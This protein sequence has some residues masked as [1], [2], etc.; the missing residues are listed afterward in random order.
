MRGPEKHK[1]AANMSDVAR[2]AGVSPQTVSRTLAGHPNVRAATAAKVLDAVEK[3]DY[4]VH[5]AAASLSSGRTRQ[6]GVI[7][8][9]SARY[10][11][12]ALGLGVEAAAVA[13]GYSV[14]T[15]AAPDLTP[16]SVIATLDRVASQGAEGI[17]LA[18]PV[19]AEHR[20]FA[21][22]AARIPM[23]A[24]DASAP[25]IPTV[26]VDQVA[27]GRLATEHLLG[28]GHRTVVHLQGPDEWLESRDRRL[29]WEVALRARDITP[30]RPLVGDWS[31]ESGYR[32]GTALATERDVTALFVASDEMAFGVLR[33]MHEHGRRVPEDLSIVSVD[34]IDL[35]AYAAPSLTTVRQPFGEIGRLAAERLIDVLEDRPVHEREHPVPE[36]VVRSST[37]PARRPA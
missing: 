4:R 21:A 22:R 32:I 24:I 12:S 16:E 36:L 2:L 15:A 20:D 26:S 25:A 34:D 8:V 37:A 28:L 27:I 33:A 3:L 23:V 10:S 9:S 35:A 29:G 13:A 5:A 7:T 31:P 19:G 1:A 11:T 6:L 17:L 30:P 18:V 14:T